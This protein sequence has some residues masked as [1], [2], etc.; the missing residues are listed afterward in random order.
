MRGPSSHP[1]VALNVESWRLVERGGGGE[2]GFMLTPTS[3]LAALLLARLNV[4]KLFGTPDVP[5][6][7]VTLLA[8]WCC[9]SVRFGV[10]VTL[11]VRAIPAGK[12]A[13][14]CGSQCFCCC[15][16]FSY[17]PLLSFFKLAP[18]YQCAA[19]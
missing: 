19:K 17:S 11:C 10:C 18:L 6:G 1:V 14:Q 9:C 12:C 3:S 8:R 2:G 16:C 7:V 4:S 5:W 15:C 13:R